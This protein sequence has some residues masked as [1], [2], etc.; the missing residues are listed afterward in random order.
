MA[1][2]KVVENINEDI[3]PEIIIEGS[4]LNEVG[5]DPVTDG[6]QQVGNQ[7]VIAS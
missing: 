5:L 7:E 6:I 1:N 2:D 4:F 3:H